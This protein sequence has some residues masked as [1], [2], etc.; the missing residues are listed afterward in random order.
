MQ[1]CAS[2]SYDQLEQSSSG[3]IIRRSSSGNHQQA[4]II[5]SSSSGGHHQ[6]VPRLMHGPACARAA[7]HGATWQ[8]WCTDL[9]ARPDR[10]DAVAELLDP[11]AAGEQLAVHRLDVN[12]LRPEGA[13]RLL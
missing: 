3:D 8:G 11:V 9:L 2:S 4:V 5:G 13:Q 12:V 10:G 7:I 6:G 1:T